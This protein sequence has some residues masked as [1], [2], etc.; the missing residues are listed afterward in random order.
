MVH[1]VGWGHTP[2][3]KL[4]ALSLEDLIREAGAE[5]LAHAGVSADDIDGIWVTGP[6]EEAHVIVVGQDFVTAGLR[7]D[8]TYEDTSDKEDQP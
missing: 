6:T 1:I 3:G 2:F 4:S 8:V 7:V 5:A